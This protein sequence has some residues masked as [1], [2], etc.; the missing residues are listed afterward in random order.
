MSIIRNQKRESKREEKRNNAKIAELEMSFIKEVGASGIGATDG[1]VDLEDDIYGKIYKKYLAK[2][3]V[4]IEIMTDNKMFKLT[5]PNRMYF[6][7]MYNPV[8]GKRIS[9][10]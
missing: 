1:K 2:Y 8:D 10:K 6:K 4:T 9:V 7:E 3:L 5:T